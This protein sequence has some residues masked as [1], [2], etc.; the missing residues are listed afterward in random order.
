MNKVVRTKTQKMFRRTR[1]IFIF[2]KFALR[3]HQLISSKY[4]HTYVVGGAIR[5]VLLHKKISDVDFATS[6]TPMQIMRILDDNNI[7]YSKAHMQFGI[8]IA[9][10]GNQ[11]IEIATFR[12]EQYGQSRFP[13]IKFTKSAKLDS[14]RRD[15]TI[16]ALYY[17]LETKE[18][19]DF[20]EGLKDIANRTLRFIGKAEKRIQE[21]PLRIARAYRLQ[22]Q[23]NLH[24]EK[25]TEHA[26]QTNMHLLKT[27]SATR[28]QKEINLVTT[29]N[30]K[31]KL[32]K[33]IHNNT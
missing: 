25:Q 26:L 3:I 30:L 21:D 31:N 15:F 27:I 17:S 24:F 13:K 8:V 4:Q 20:H 5:N 16:N 10:S 9:T 11:K 22:L 19:Q 6:A 14:K 23:Y 2:P 33:V 7:P 12:T 32:Q 18:I 1:D 28:V 29:Q